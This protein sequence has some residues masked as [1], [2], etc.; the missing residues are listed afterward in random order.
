MKQS[1]AFATGAVRALENGLLPRSFFAALQQADP[2]ERRRMLVDRGFAGFA[3][4]ADPD[5][6]TRDRM[7]AVYE[8]L[9]PYLPD[10]GVL[11]VCLLPHDFHNLK[12]ALKGVLRGGE[13]KDLYLRPAKFDPD[14]LWQAITSRDPDALPPFL[15]EA[16][17]EGYEILTATGDGQQMDL[18]LDRRCLEAQLAAA[19]RAGAIIERWAARHAVYADLRIALRLARQEPGDALIDCALAEAPGL[20]TGLLKEAIRAGRGAVAALI[21]E[22][23]DELPDPDGAGAAAL[24]KAMDD[25]LSQILAETRSVPCGPEVVAAYYL[26]REIERKN[27]CILASF[28]DRPERVRERLRETDA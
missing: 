13:R 14:G 24:E 26:R 1:F 23:F 2:A 22:R 20:D 27:V 18:E 21:R 7:E 15:R 6:A 19:P 12:A 9:L 4:T 28:G 25:Q 10:P 11:D 17:K 5:L 8:E 3:D 16:A